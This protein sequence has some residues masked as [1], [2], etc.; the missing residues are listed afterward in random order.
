MWKDGT[1]E[2]VGRIS[3]R[4][5]FGVEERQEVV[6]LARWKDVRASLH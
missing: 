3:E 4:M 5:E 1:M 6:V 2:Q